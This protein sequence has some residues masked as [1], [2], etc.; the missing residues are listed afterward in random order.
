MQTGEQPFAST[1]RGIEANF[2]WTSMAG[3]GL[4]GIGFVRSFFCFSFG[5][6]AG[7]ISRCQKMRVGTGRKGFLPA[8]EIEGDFRSTARGIDAKFRWTSMAGIGLGGIGF[9]RSFFCFS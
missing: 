8:R 3:M 5:A 2:R 6:A 1:A 9:V 4:G 7:T